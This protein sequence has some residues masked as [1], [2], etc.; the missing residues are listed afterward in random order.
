MNPGLG[1]CSFQKALTCGIAA[2]FRLSA[3][4]TISALPLCVLALGIGIGHDNSHATCGHHLLATS[5]S[6]EASSRRCKTQAC[7]ATD[8]PAKLGT[9]WP[10]A[11]AAAA[12]SAQ[13]AGT[14]AATAAP[15]CE[16]SGWRRGPERHRGALCCQHHL[17]LR[18]GPAG[19]W[20]GSPRQPPSAAPVIQTARPCSPPPADGCRP[21]VAGHAAPGLLHRAPAAPGGSVWGAAGLVLGPRHGAAR[22]ARQPGRGPQR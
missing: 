5:S 2:A 10:E 21:A 4:P 1:A 9:P 12:R 18:P 6:S 22:P 17:C 3:P 7:R 13:A 16:L 19:E 14:Q 15:A 11:A 8:G 20:Q